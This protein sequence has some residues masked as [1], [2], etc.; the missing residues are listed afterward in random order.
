MTKAVIIGGAGHIGTYLVPLLVNNGFEVVVISRGIS[1]P[2][3]ENPAWQR[4]KTVQLDRGREPD[5]AKRIADIQADVV[6]D[7]INFDVL[8]TKKMVAALKGTACQHYLYCSSCWARGFAD[9]G[10]RDGDWH[11]PM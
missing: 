8:E 9:I 6:V 7:L 11:S 1:K 3:V 5:F 10:K 2:Y 4:V